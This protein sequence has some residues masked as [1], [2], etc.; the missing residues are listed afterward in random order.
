MKFKSVFLKIFKLS[1]LR[2][3]RSSLIHSITAEGKKE[4]WKK[5]CFTLNR[6]ILLVFLVL[7]VLTEVRIIPNRHFG[8]LYLKI[9]DYVTISYDF[10]RKSCF[11][12]RRWRN[13]SEKVVMDEEELD[14]IGNLEDL[15]RLVFIDKNYG[16]LKVS[17][18]WWWR[19]YE[20]Y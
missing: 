13:P 12:W 3:F 4:F 14:G 19:P 16:N 15:P 1:V 7:Y 18:R 17:I 5:L 2:I 11:H 10:Q 9:H 20:K 8:H 6:G